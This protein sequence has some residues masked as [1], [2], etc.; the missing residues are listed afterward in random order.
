MTKQEFA[1]KAAEYGARAQYSG[2]GIAVASG[3]TLYDIGVMVGIFTAIAGL[4]V[5]WYYRHRSFKL[6]QLRHQAEL[7]YIAKHGKQITYLD[8]DKANEQSS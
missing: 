8:P 4:V 7:A 5:T 1:E 3:L 6:E 2:A